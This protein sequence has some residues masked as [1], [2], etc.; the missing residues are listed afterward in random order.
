M[1]PNS[2]EYGILH[3]S[4]SNGILGFAIAC[5]FLG[6]TSLKTLS[7][8]PGNLRGH[9]GTH[10]HTIAPIAIAIVE[11]ATTHCLQVTNLEESVLKPCMALPE[12][13]SRSCGKCKSFYI[14]CVLLFTSHSQISTKYPYISAY[15][16]STGLHWS[17][18]L[19]HP[20]CCMVVQQTCSI[21]F[22][23]GIPGSI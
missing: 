22:G 4:S 14:Q 9:R 18:V 7:A 12:M 13:Y 2:P 6:S 8:T 16:K 11:V 20:L 19:Y 5:H 10:C 1:G 17:T 3:K 23:S 15:Q 21:L